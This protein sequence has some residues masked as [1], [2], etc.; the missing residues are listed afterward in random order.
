MPP[1]MVTVP[2]EGPAGWLVGS[3]PELGNWDPDQGIPIGPGASVTL[4]A[5]SVLEWK[6]VTRNPDGSVRWPD[7]PNQYALVSS[8]TTVIAR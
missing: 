5:G 7:G 3:G 8:E 6:H 2:I 1:T 4:P